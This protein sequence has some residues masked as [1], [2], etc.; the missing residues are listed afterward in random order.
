MLSLYSFYFHLRKKKS[1]SSRYPLICIVAIKY[2]VCSLIL[3]GN[4]CSMDYMFMG[5]EGATLLIRF[6]KLSPPL[7]CYFCSSAAVLWFGMQQQ[8]GSPCSLFSCQS[9]LCT[10]MLIGSNPPLE[11]VLVAW[12]R[13]LKDILVRNTKE[14]IQVA[15]K[16]GTEHSNT[17]QFP[18]W[19]RERLKG[20]R[21]KG[22]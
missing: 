10:K 14:P 13:T 18:H 1:N 6:G 16:R 4:E 17:I 15:K 5:C 9:P 20:R 22:E 2:M 19:K 8:C 21:E 12:P 3:Q 11:A 7:F